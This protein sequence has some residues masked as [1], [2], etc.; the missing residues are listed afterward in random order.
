VAA[1]VLGAVGAVVAGGIGTIVVVLAVAALS[2]ELR[3]L[4]RL[5]QPAAGSQ[6]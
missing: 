2:P 1:A 5:D 6:Q 4:G 3:N